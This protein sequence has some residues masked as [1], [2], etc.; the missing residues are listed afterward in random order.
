MLLHDLHMHV[1][2]RTLF[3]V[4]S[5]GWHFFSLNLGVSGSS[6][7]PE[8]CDSCQGRE[9]CE[10]AGDRS[11][12]STLAQVIPQGQLGSGSTSVEHVK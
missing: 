9:P 2:K 5:I 8:A 7:S 11:L 4:N 6:V 3:A 1:N 12:T 10:R